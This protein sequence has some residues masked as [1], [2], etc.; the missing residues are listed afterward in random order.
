MEKDM[1]VKRG[2]FVGTHLHESERTSVW[3]GALAN[4]FSALLGCV[5][6]A[7]P[8]VFFHG[9]AAVYTSVYIALAMLFALGAYLGRLSKE[10]ILASGLKIIIITLLIVLFNVLIGRYA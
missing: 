2:Y 4:A 1:G 3:H 6:P 5:I 9:A 10:N 8:L 7:L